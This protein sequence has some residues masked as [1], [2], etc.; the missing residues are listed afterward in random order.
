MAL[1]HRILVATDFSPGAERAVDV[2]AHLAAA[3]EAPLVLA[4]VYATAPIFDE[5]QRW[6]T[7][8][9]DTGA[10]RG[11]LERRLDVLADRA[12]ERGA[13]DVE[14]AL[15]RDDS[16]T[17]IV[18]LAQDRGCDLIVLG[19]PRA[20]AEGAVVHDVLRAAPCPV[21]VAGPA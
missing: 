19:S 13:H 9:A 16:A 12:R 8:R 3:F 18:A 7:P 6:P 5:A 15:G 21:L 20:G 4:H 14:T 10:V 2:A 1:V 17:A 11:S